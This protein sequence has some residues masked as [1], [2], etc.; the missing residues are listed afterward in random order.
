MDYRIEQ[1]SA[2]KII[3]FEGVFDYKT[4]YA[5]IPKFWD[6]ICAKFI[7]N[8]NAGNTPANPHEKA[9]ADNRIGEYGVCIDD[10]CGGKFRYLIAGK[11]AGGDV[12]EGMT[13]YEL[14][15]SDW[16]IFDCI[17]PMPESLQS[18]NTRVFNEWL[19]NNPDYE[20][21]GVAN[22]E[23]YDCKNSENTNADCHS[24][25]WVPVKKK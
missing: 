4:A 18:L 1:M 3:G 24:A 7:D 6:E 20:F 23:W 10:M 19:P 9:V 21:H 2:F 25:I 17:G 11:Y 16:A 5:E 12:P 15:K 8:V 14:P 13:L 22:I